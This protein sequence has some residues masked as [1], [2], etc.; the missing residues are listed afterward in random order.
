MSYSDYGSSIEPPDRPLIVKCTFDRSPKRISFTSAVN[1]KYELL[2]TKIEQ[3]FSLSAIPFTI[4][5]KDDDGEITVIAN[6]FD[7]VEA[8]QYFQAGDD[9]PGSSN[10]SVTSYRSGAGR[11]IT[12]R[13]Q[14]K[15]DYDGPG[16]SDT[17]SLASRDDDF[18]HGNRQSWSLSQTEGSEG[19]FSLEQEDDAMTVSSRNPG[20]SSDPVIPTTTGSQRLPLPSNYRLPSHS[21]PSVATSPP[22]PPLSDQFVPLNSS[23]ANSSYHNLSVQGHQTDE[24][25]R[26][27][28]PSTAGPTKGNQLSASGSRD[29][30]GSSVT[31]RETETEPP[32]TAVFERLRLAE[33]A[34]SSASSTS[35]YGAIPSALTSQERGVKW[36]Q[37]QNART[38]HNILGAPAASSSSDA[39]SISLSIDDLESRGPVSAAENNIRGDLAL[40]QGPRG[41]YY[42]TYTSDSGSQQNGSQANVRYSMS[43]DALASPIDRR[44]STSSQNLAWLASHQFM[45]TADRAPTQVSGRSRGASFGRQNSAPLVPSKLGIPSPASSS[46]SASSRPLP[47]LPEVSASTK[48]IDFSSIPKELLP[49][50]PPDTLPPPDQ[51]TDCSSCGVILDTFRYVCSICGPKKTMSRSEHAEQHARLLQEHYDSLQDDPKGK[52]RAISIGGNGSSLTLQSPPRTT[53]P[54]R[55]DSL[56]KASPS[57]SISPSWSILGGG[58]DREPSSSSPL[59]TLSNLFRSKPK[60]FRKMPSRPSMR[61]SSTGD[62]SETGSLL[63]LPDTAVAQVSPP[64]GASPISPSSPRQLQNH[65]HHAPSPIRSTTFDQGFELC[66]DCIYTAGVSHAYEGALDLSQGHSHSH[67]QSQYGLSSSAETLVSANNFGCPASPLSSPEEAEMTLRRSAPTQKGRTRHAFVESVWDGVERG[68]KVIEQEDK[69]TCSICDASLAI[70]RYKCISCPQF[71]LCDGC[72]GQVHEIHPSHAFLEVP[73][74]SASTRSTSP[75]LVENTGQEEQSLKHPDV[76]CYNCGLDI[77]GARFH[78]AVCKSVDI[79]QNCESA[80]LPGNLTNTDGGHDSSHIMIKIPYPLDS[81]EVAFASRRARVLWSERDAA[82]IDATTKRVTPRSR[83][84]SID[85]SYAATVIAPKRVRLTNPPDHQ[86]RCNGCNGQIIGVRYQCA[87]CPS[88]PVGYNLCHQCERMSF[89]IHPLPHVFIKF[90]RRVDRPIQSR[91]PLVPVLYEEPADGDFVDASDERSQLFH[92]VTYCDRCMTQ[93]RGAWYHCVYCAADMCDMHEQTHNV[94]HCCLVFKS[95]VNLHVLQTITDIDNP[96]HSTALFHPVY[97]SSS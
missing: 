23:A 8:V 64:G 32:P 76:S 49:F 15:V 16:L 37:E 81:T 86:M 74:E 45:R 82:T 89:T 6:D 21:V 42:Y 36:L 38:L 96:N 61:S 25:A 1:C 33:Q 55:S 19:A 60:G 10:A 78:C 68:W 73:D 90:N 79:C 3:S 39:S 87:N 63:S 41:R 13:V 27:N 71:D 2:R 58:G 52:G 46:S 92:E 62:S 51:I 22:S 77:V 5:Y 97:L 72:Y 4:S 59:S 11:K 31:L 88:A 18:P 9:T 50:L 7:L 28:T 30:L 53:Y 93:I 95:K 66:S 14:V 40:Q 43:S 26:S 65:H 47:K 75:T 56:T 70:R 44:I 91:E 17:A 84:N 69:R 20:V 85:S 48:D 83:S 29:R 35:P 12:M 34:G 94:D 24:A 57:L 80:G 67:N 54:P